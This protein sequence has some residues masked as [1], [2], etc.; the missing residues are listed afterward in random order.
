[1][2]AA[3]GRGER[4][5]RR[6]EATSIS[7]G[8][9]AAA[10]VG[11]NLLAQAVGRRRPCHDRIPSLVPCPDGGSF[12]SDQT[13]AA[14]AAAAFL[15]WLRPSLRGWLGG[16][17]AAVAVARVGAGAHYVTD[18]IAGAALGAGL[19]R[20]ARAVAERRLGPGESEAAPA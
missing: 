18:V 3:I 16:G 6:I 13:A 20:V 19:A 7:V 15:G 12:P 11:S 2:A 5:L 14:V 9:V 10:L 4:P 17:A 1:M 8:T